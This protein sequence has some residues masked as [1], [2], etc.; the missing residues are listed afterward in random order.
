M[1]VATDDSSLGNVTN[2]PVTVDVLANDTTGDAVDPT[3][4]QI[5]GTTN[6]GDDLVVVGEGTWSVDP[7]SGAIT[8]TPEPGFTD[9]PTDI[10]YTVD[11]VE[12]NT[13]NAAVVAVGYDQQP[14]VA[15]DDESLGQPCGPGDVECAR[16]FVFGWCG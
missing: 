8:F 9:D 2:T 6:P 16:W 3:S 1:P 14:P 13:S 10:T 15:V 5:V 12:G 4:V 7:V 11:D